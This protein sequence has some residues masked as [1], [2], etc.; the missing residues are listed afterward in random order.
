METWNGETVAYRTEGRIAYITLN[1]P[2]AFN[3]ITLQT[4]GDLQRA[5]ELANENSAVH[6]IVLSG[7]GKAFCS[8]YD[9]KIFAETKGPTFGSQAEPWDPLVDYQLMH[10]CT[11][12]FMSLWRSLK[13][14]ICKVHGFAVAGGSDIALC[15]D[16]IVMAD[17]AMIGYPPARVWGC[18]TTAQWVYRIGPEKAKRMLLTGDV[19]SGKEAKELGLVHAAVPA[20]Q[21][22]LAVARLAERIASVPKN[23][24]MMQKLVINKAVEMTGISVTQTLATLLDGVA[25]HSPEGREFKRRCEEVGFKQAVRERD[26]G[27]SPP[28]A[29]L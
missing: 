20:D 9:L 17:D 3:A 16:L 7:A 18:P 2:H 10:K 13:P 4:P 26:S 19:I 8:G 15:S 14:V 25:R 12:G 22:D 21:L 24:L 11:D 6:V 5:V 1:R 29:K 28:A 23:Q 27:I